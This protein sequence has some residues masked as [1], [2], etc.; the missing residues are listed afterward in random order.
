M[1][2]CRAISLAGQRD[3]A[4]LRIECRL[5]A[6]HRLELGAGDLVT[7]VVARADER[8]RLDVLEAEVQRGA[9][10]LGELV[11]VVVTLERE[12]LER[13]SQVLADREDVAVDLAQRL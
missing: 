1:T 9:L 13:R 3:D 6:A 5:A 7:G 4:T 2:C 12:V 10:H 8:T 11:G